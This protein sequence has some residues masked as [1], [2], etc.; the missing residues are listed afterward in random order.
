MEQLNKNFY[1]NQQKY[2]NNF[3]R[4]ACL[5][6]IIGLI[7]LWNIVFP[8]L[9]G[10]A[11]A[12]VVDPF[13]NF[14]TKIH[15]NRAWATLLSTLSLLIIILYALFYIT[16]AIILALNKLF[17]SL[18]ESLS[19][20]SPFYQEIVNWLSDHHIHISQDK[21]LTSIQTGF[22]K[23][24]ESI[25]SSIMKLMGS[26]LKI[27]EYVFISML[28][29]Y[30]TLIEKQTFL[31]IVK[32]IIPDNKKE[33]MKIILSSSIHQIRAFVKSLILLSFII[34]LFMLI[35]LYSFSTPFAMSL[36]IFSGIVSIIPYIG[37][38]LHIIVIAFVQFT[39]LQSLSTI[40]WLIVA[41]GIF[42]TF[43]AFYLHPLITGKSVHIHPIIIILCIVLGGHL[44]GIFGILISIPIFIIGRTILSNYFY[45]YLQMEPPK[46]DEV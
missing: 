21:L 41:Q 25:L 23:T 32:L 45:K 35:L 27:I 26:S 8:F 22:T 20:Q 2:L 12:F 33:S 5:L 15:I 44:G 31:K 46:S 10:I 7:Y 18:S 19:V 4:G 36:A 11:I 29:F 30:Y 16:P 1:E 42:Y 6:F 14:L 9:L 43:V 24:I 39:Q 3:F 40:I 38:T 28:T 17:S 37:P 13:I 34:F